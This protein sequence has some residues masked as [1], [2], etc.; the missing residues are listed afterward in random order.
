RTGVLWS[1]DAASYSAARLAT[2]KDAMTPWGRP[3]VLDTTF[4]AQA[5]PHY[6]EIHRFLLRATGRFGDA[7]DLAKET[8]LRAYRAYRSSPPVEDSRAWLFTLAANAFRNHLRSQK[9]GRKAFDAVN[10]LALQ[11]E[12]AGPEAVAEG[13][14]LGVAVEK[15]V[16]AL[17]VKQRIAFLQRKVHGLD[18]PCIGEAIGSSPETARAHVFQALKKIRKA[19]EA[20]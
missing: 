1:V 11:G 2:C 20:S 5:L 7:E 4:E 18:Y 15:V 17:P 8:F 9:R 16:S 14:E 10:A 13:R 3:P 12:S 6:R 19:L